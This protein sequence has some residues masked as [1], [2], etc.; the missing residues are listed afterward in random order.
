MADQR[1]S[2][3]LG[4]EGRNLSRLILDKK[5]ELPRYREQAVGAV[6]AALKRNRSVL[7]VGDVGVGKTSVVHGVGNEL[8]RIARELW[9]LPTNAVLT[10]TRYLGDWP[11]KV[12]AIL[13]AL[14]GRRGVLYVP[15]IWNVLTVGT[16]SS[17]PTALFDHLRPRMLTG[18][19]QLIGEVTPERLLGLQSAP[20]F[21]SLFDVVPI[22]PLEENQISSL[23]TDYAASRQ[24]PVDE[25]AIR[26]LMTLCSR[27]LPGDRG[28]G[29]LLRL[30]QQI[31]DYQREKVAIGEP[32][33][34]DQA[35]IEKVFS[36]YSGLPRFVVSR[37]VTKPAREIREWFRE[38]IIGQERAIESVV[39]V[40]TLFK[41]GLHDPT[42]PIGTLLFVG[43]T[44]VGKTELAKALAQYLFGSE[45]RLLRFD[46]SEFKDYHAFQ[47]LVGDP[48]KPRQPAR[49]LDPIR[50]QPFQVILFDEIEKA[51]QNVWDMLL[52]LLD[53][54]HVSPPNGAR[55]NFRNTIVIATSNV[56][57]QDAHKGPLGFVGSPSGQISLKSLESVFRPELLNRFQHI[58]TFD[59]LTRES[60]RRIANREIQQLLAREGITS[61]NLCVEVGEDVLDAVVETGFDREYGARALKRQVQQRVLFPI[62][63][64]LMESDV[65]PGSILKLDIASHEPDRS[66][67]GS[68]R[69]RVLESEASRS[70]RREAAREL[71]ANKQRRS[72]IEMNDEARKLATRCEELAKY[73]NKDALT[74]RLSEL[75]KQRRAAHFWRDVA[76]ANEALVEMDELKEVLMRL[77]SLQT[78]IDGL[79][80]ELSRPNVRQLEV[81]ER[82]IDQITADLE[83]AERELVRM[84]G[85]GAIDALIAITPIG[86]STQLR[87]LLFETYRGWADEIGYH[88]QLLADPLTPSDA[89]FFAVKGAYAHGYLER[90]QGVHRLREAEEHEA[91]RVTIARWS[92]VA[93]NVEFGNQRALKQRGTFGEKVRSRVEVIGGS[94]FALQNALTI[95]ENRELARAIAASWQAASSSDTVVRRY[96]L[97]PFL[98]KDHLTGLTSGR[99][100]V[101]KPAE[102]HELLCKRVDLGGARA[103]FHLPRV[104]R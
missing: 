19:V 13:Q 57:A 85:D 83:V 81:L 12:E 90:E 103:L 8:P 32:E 61:R 18:E 70:Y 14:K 26:E 48:N 5:L 58:V 62:A 82:S 4:Q 95:A 40:I 63:S 9:E 97:E 31:A 78:R 28:P 64:R 35:F 37:S 1:Y 56:G 38:R 17:D 71:A 45:S 22:V 30:I 46:L 80:Q 87:D 24:I 93:A 86:H 66:T 15:D 25:R 52:Q 89:T 72:V 94:H 51:H 104:G 10:G 41:A 98:L 20:L 39:E 16:S 69:V 29:Q 67:P 96:D 43:P 11:S 23:A 88:T 49:L 34:I 65:P 55:A 100:S 75:D 33:L 54:G 102:F 21:T 77:E 36:I 74:A 53:E 42:R 92:H 6:L 99:R 3:A 50:A 60:V 59:G 68:T 27:F 44:G 2:D 73:C 101:L 7:L 47:L 84:G 79:S 91:V 76:L